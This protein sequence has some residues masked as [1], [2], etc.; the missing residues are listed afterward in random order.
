MTS[1]SLMRFL[2]L[3]IEFM[4]STR[5]RLHAFHFDFTFMK[6]LNCLVSVVDI[7]HRKKNTNIQTISNKKI[8]LY[9]VNAG[10]STSSAT[11]HAGDRV[12]GGGSKTFPFNLLLINQMKKA[13]HQ[14]LFLSPNFR[15]CY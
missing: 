1:C 11:R 8:V 15:H 10:P 14:T 2:S 9:M 3:S 5:Y 6:K 7:R 13:L 12:A 4:E